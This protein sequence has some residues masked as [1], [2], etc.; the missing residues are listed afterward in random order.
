M[1][2]YLLQNANDNFSSTRFAPKK[3][4]ELQ[5]QNQKHKPKMQRLNV[6]YKIISLL[7]DC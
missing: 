1:I 4:I 7:D 5:K 6:W 2:D 3:Q